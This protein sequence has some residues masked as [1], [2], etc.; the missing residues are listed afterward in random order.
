LLTYRAEKKRMPSKEEPHIQQASFPEKRLPHVKE[1]FLTATSSSIWLLVIFWRRVIRVLILKDS[2]RAEKKRMPSKEE[3]HIQQAS[4]PEKR[5]LPLP[6]PWDVRSTSSIH[7]LMWKK[8]FLLP[9]LQASG[10][11]WSFEEG[12]TGLKR[13]ECH[14]KKSLTSNKLHF[15]KNDFYLSLCLESLSIRSRFSGNE[16]CWMWGS[17]FDGILIF[18]AL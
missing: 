2:Y 14:Q 8:L 16:A 9:L 4:F 3:P 13:W 1:A 12:L 18:S 10:Y 6:L 15:L 17:S 7:H 5:L 11:W